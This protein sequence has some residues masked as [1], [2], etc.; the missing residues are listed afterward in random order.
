MK[1]HIINLLLGAAFLG[2]VCWAAKA[3]GLQAWIPLILAVILGIVILD[4]KTSYI[5]EI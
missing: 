3:P 2:C 1:K 4:R 5:R